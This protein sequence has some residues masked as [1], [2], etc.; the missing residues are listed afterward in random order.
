LNSIRCDSCRRVI[1]FDDN[2]LERNKGKKFAWTFCPHCGNATLIINKGE[3]LY[4]AD[5]A[6]EI[7]KVDVKPKRRGRKPKEKKDAE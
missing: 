2:V 1:I 3:P 6:T 4:E 7:T 5:D